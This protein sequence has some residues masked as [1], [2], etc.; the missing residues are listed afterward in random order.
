MGYTKDVINPKKKI[1]IKAYD[2]EER[3]TKGMVILPI[4]VGLDIKETICQVLDLKLAY[5]ILLGRP[6]ICDM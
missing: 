2:D 5:N 4:R 1:T 6:W 3:S